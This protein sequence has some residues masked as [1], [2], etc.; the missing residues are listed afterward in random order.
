MSKFGYLITGV[1]AGF[2]AAHFVNQSPGGRRFFEQVNQG[3]R[4]FSDAVAA[5]YRD[6]EAG[7]DEVAADGVDA[8]VDR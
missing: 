6:A 5:G 3:M 2:V 8:D 4:E 7:R 1:A